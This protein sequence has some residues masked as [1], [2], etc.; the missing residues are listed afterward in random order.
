MINPIQLAINTLFESFS[1]YEMSFINDTYNDKE[2]IANIISST[3]QIDSHV[4]RIF[5]PS[6]NDKKMIL[7]SLEGFSN[8]I[9][10]SEAIELIE[11]DDSTPKVQKASLGDEKLL[12]AMKQALG[13]I[14]HVVSNGLNEK[15]KKQKKASTNNRGEITARFCLMVLHETVIGEPEKGKRD[16]KFLIDKYGGEFISMENFYTFY[17]ARNK[18]L[19]SDFDGFSD[20]KA[21]R[22]RA[23]IDNLEV[24]S[25][26]D[27]IKSHL[28]EALSQYT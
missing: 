12:N 11:F 3:N 22:I 10:E 15:E 16:K 13:Q 25:P 7:E 9:K 6:D 26:T 27:K 24:D 28:R 14:R 20:D 17:K 23:L 8:R 1:K 19:D 18:I 21:E 5:Y 2:A 4:L